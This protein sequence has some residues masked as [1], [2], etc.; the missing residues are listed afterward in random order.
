MEL[1]PNLD[2]YIRNLS[3]RVQTKKPNAFRHSVNINHVLVID[4][5]L[6]H[7]HQQYRHTFQYNQSLEIALGTSLS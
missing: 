6:M 1:L 3:K 2:F 4:R 5:L 7:K